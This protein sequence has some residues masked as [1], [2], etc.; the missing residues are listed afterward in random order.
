[1]KYAFGQRF[2][3]ASMTR[4]YKTFNKMIVRFLFY[5]DDMI[6]LPKNDTV[7]RRIDMNVEIDDAGERTI[8]P[9]DVVKGVIDNSDNI[10]IMN[11]C[12]CR[13]SSSCEDYPID[14]GCIFLGKGV[15]RIPS[16]FGHLA[17][18]EEAKAYIDECGDLGM[19]HIIG[20]N[21]I[22]SI[23]L[24]TGKKHDLMTICNCCPCCCLW[25]VTRDISDEIGGMFRRMDSV[26]VSVDND[27]CDGCGI[28]TESCFTTALSLEDGKAIIDQK[29]CRGCGRCIDNCPKD[30]LRITFDDSVVAGEIDR[31]STLVNL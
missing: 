22:D 8:L 7:T 9:S 20:R 6:V 15:H 5:E 23:W 19:I 17:S 26:E 31:I 12:L 28:C 2:R 18:K 27:V 16:D 14:H 1:M 10:F 11:F 30:A 3:L 29:L 4:K 13:L 24:S 21:K 25:N